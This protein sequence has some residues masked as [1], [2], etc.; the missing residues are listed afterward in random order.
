MKIIYS[1][2]LT[3]CLFLSSI[4]AE[5]FVF[6][7]SGK[8]VLLKDDKTWE[9]VEKNKIGKHNQ[10][11]MFDYL[12]DFRDYKYK[13]VNIIGHLNP[14]GSERTLYLKHDEYKDNLTMYNIDKLSRSE[15]KEIKICLSKGCML[16][17]FGIGN[18]SPLNQ[19]AVL[20]EKVLIIKKY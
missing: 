11:D 18:V 1:I 3:F 13:K 10:M 14:Y 6:T 12:L 5:E 20:V 16:S 17:V 15:R 2:I 9:Y 19:P 7:N 4:F 8:K